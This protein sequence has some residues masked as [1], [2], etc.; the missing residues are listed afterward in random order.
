MKK[1]FQL[2][3]TLRISRKI[4]EMAEAKFVALVTK[5]KALLPWFWIFSSVL[6][7]SRA[8]TISNLGTAKTNKMSTVDKKL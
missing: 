3:D 2:L 7:R 5:T 1:D 6:R 4:G 8:E